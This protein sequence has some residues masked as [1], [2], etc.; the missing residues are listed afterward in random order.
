FARELD[1]S[2][3]LSLLLPGTFLEEGEAHGLYGR[4]HVGCGCE[5]ERPVSPMR[6]RLA[7]APLSP[8][9]LA[10]RVEP[11]YVRRSIAGRELV[12]PTRLSRSPLRAAEAPLP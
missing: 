3:V 5:G 8:R 11:E 12:S 1:G 2:S 7:E 6:P 4:K 10:E 9:R